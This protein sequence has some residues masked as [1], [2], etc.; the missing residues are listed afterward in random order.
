MIRQRKRKGRIHHQK[1]KEE[2][3]KERTKAKVKAR[4]NNKHKV[5]MKLTRD[6]N[7][8]VIEVF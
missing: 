7:L 5:I 2:E 6:K 4:R 8:K 3:V 1:M